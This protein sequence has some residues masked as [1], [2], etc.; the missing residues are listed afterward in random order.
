MHLYWFQRI[1]VDL[2][3]HHL[4]YQE[5]TTII[6]LPT[7]SNHIQN[8]IMKWLNS[9]DSNSTPMHH[10]VSSFSYCKK[11]INVSHLFIY[12]LFFLQLVW[13]FSSNDSRLLE[14]YFIWI[15]LCFSTT[16]T[17]R[18]TTLWFVW[19][20]STICPLWE[21][22]EPN[23]LSVLRWHVPQTS[24]ETNSCSKGKNLDI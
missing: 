19:K 2:Q 17:W 10:R 14:M 4:H 7:P 11:N 22:R 8:Q 6:W 3:H 20:H 15:F 21:M 12:Q 1:K 5:A 16:E 18:W 13:G 24:K 23:I 9:T